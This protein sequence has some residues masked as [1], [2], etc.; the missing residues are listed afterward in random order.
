M[1][2]GIATFITDEGI[3]PG[4]LGAAAEERGFNSLARVSDD[5]AAWQGVSPGRKGFPGLRAPMT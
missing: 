2:F 1:K 3:G 4:P 5:H